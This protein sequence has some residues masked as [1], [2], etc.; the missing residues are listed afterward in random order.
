[1]T[2]KLLLPLLLLLVPAVLSAKTTRKVEKSFS[3]SSGASIEVDISGGSI[4]VE[5]E[6]GDKTEITL[7]QTFHTH[8]EEEIDEIVKRHDI[9]LIKQ[10]E[11]I[12]VAVKRRKKTSGWFSN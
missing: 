7:I 12:I 9:I 3:I 4:E 8:S 11:D 1:M 5:I 10:G 2:R 6:D